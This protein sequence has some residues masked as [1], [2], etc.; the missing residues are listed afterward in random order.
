M[1]LLRGK[2]QMIGNGEMQWVDPNSLRL[3]PWRTTY[4]LKPDLEILARS[5][6]DYGW[7]QPLVVQVQTGIV[8]DGNYRYEVASNLSKLSKATGGLVPVIMVDCDDIEAMLLHARLNRGRGSVV[9]RK[10]SRIVQSLLRSRKYGEPDI[11]RALGMSA[12]EMDLMVDGTMLKDKKIGEHKYSAAWVPVEAPA[13]TVDKAMSIE[14]PP[15]SD[16]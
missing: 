7:L 1:K 15:N 2:H 10:L 11:K 5:L 16:G 12:D 4:L 6:E 13:G 14:R 8:I 3:A 9:A